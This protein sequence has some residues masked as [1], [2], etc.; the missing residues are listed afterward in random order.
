[1]PEPIGK[2]NQIRSRSS[3]SEHAARGEDEILALR[4]DATAVPALVAEHAPPERG[5]LDLLCA[6]HRLKIK[7]V[8]GHVDP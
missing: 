7:S 5:A 2:S 3:T 1:M 4:R 8:G 6:P